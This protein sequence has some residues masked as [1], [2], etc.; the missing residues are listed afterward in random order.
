M[1]T[2]ERGRNKIKRFEAFR[3][4]AYQD[5]VGV[6]TIGYG[7]TV[8]VRE[9]DTMTQAQADARLDAELV[10]Y[11]RAVE[12]AAGPCNQNQFDALVSLAW[13]IGIKGMSG[14]SAVKA[15][16]R[17]DFQAAARAFALWNKAG[18]K[19]WPGLT[20][21]RA[22][23]AALYLEP[24]VQPLYEE[25]NPVEEMPQAVDA[26]KPMSRSSIMTAGTATAAVSTVSVVAQ[27]SQEVRT[28]KDTLGDMLPW[29]LLG[30]ALLGIVFGG[31]TMLERY[32]QR[33]D[34]WA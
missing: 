23:E 26:E 28:I 31:W 13:N 12:A 7:F 11:E 33:R 20:R 15:H 24:V 1:K 10:P 30:A 25:A 9:G 27:V 14:S 18:G 4:T 16:R 34:G 17:G 5:V 29:I 22:A 6:W 3:G 2:S 8:G 21:R 19:V 32:K